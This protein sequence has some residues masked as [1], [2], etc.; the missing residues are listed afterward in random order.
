M[1]GTLNQQWDLNSLY[2]N[3]SRSDRLHELIE[4]LN[5]TITRVNKDLT[6]IHT[7]SGHPDIPQLVK[8]LDAFQFALSGWEELDDFLY[9]VYAEDL[10]DSHAL[11]L[12]DTSAVIQANLQSVQLDLDYSLAGFPPDAWTEFLKL[13]EIK[14]IAFYLESRRSVVKNRLSVEMERLINALSVNGIRAWE[15]QHELHLTQLEV[16]LEID[17]E[18][19]NVSIEEALNE[20]VHA[21]NRSNRQRAAAAIEKTCEASAETFAAILNRIAGF[22]LD[23][24]EQRGWSNLLTE[25]VE[26]NQIK[27][28]TI[29]TMIS[30]LDSNKGLYQAF[31]QRKM[32]LAG[33]GNASW[34]DLESPRFASAEKVPYAAAK[35][36]ILKQFHSFSKKLGDFAEQ[37]FDN[38]WLETENRPGKTEGGFCASMP[39]AKESRIFWTYR[40]NYR[41]IVT[42]AHELGHAY[43]NSI[44]HEE[45]AF[46]QQKG[47]SVAETASTFMENL[48]LE[49]V[50]SETANEQE[51][52]ALLEIKIL[53]G[54]KYAGMIPNMFRFEQ[55]F[56]EQRKN[57]LLTVEDITSLITDVENDFFGGV[58]EDTGIYKWMYISHFYG[59]E[60][61]FYNIPYTIGYLF[62][63]GI[64]AMAQKEGSGFQEHYDDLLRNSGSMTVE[65]L[66]QTYLRA[67]LTQQTFWDQSQQSLK[68]AIEEYLQLTEKFR[69]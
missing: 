69:G 39:L 31:I 24:Y 17:G 49:A 57:G 16:A 23:V 59:A 4:N 34:F 6:E 66:A 15:Q 19:K 13:D 37:A 38:G 26:Q 12:M 51:K 1:D 5:E 50:I 11:N 43:H 52:L 22:R 62:S 7:N 29:Q 48:V 44:L 25:I 46:A 35:D 53:E 55:Q 10:K 45:P 32:E 63:N 18:S 42:L 65:Q 20:A 27:E 61:A 40:D 2:E 58:I 54:I 60:K 36:I 47:T 28:E 3:G 8:T 56:Y 33:A 67:D 30:S 21:E 41:D 64:Y 9:C 14:P 68:D